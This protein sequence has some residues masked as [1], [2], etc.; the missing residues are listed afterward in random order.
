M[1]LILDD[2]D[3]E[4]RDVLD[5]VTA[6]LPDLTLRHLYARLL[7]GSPDP[8][9]RRGEPAVALALAVFEEKRSPEH[10]ETLAMAYAAAGRF[11]EALTLQGRL[12]EQARA[13]EV[14]AGFIGRVERN[15]TRYRAGQPGVFGW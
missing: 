5:T 2:R 12:L 4:A 10:A 15:L 9:V 14:D 8:S 7:A 11:D 6:R 13:E 3:R 1:A